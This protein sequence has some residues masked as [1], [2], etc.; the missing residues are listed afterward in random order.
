MIDGKEKSPS[1]AFRC[2]F[3]RCDVLLKIQGFRN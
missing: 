3:R 2:M 1:A